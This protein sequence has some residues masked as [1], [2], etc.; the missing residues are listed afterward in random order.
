M[1]ND[2]LMYGGHLCRFVIRA[3]DACVERLSDGNTYPP[4][5]VYNAEPIPL[6][7][8]FLESN[9]FEERGED[10]SYY[11]LFPSND[12]T[13]TIRNLSELFVTFNHLNNGKGRPRSMIN[14]PVRY[15][16]ELQNVLR[17]VGLCD[18]ANDLS[19][20]ALDGTTR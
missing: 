12:Y 2:L 11:C 5:A 14:V 9:D 8:K 15:V 17:C 3:N 18:M 13:L 7:N 19:V 20:V 4:C 6:T 16:H 10:E 1:D